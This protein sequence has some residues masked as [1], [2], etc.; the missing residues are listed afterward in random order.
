MYYRNKRN[1]VAFGPNQN[2]FG[3][4]HRAGGAHPGTEQRAVRGRLMLCMVSSMLG[5]LGLGQASDRENTEHQE[6]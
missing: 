1:R 2:N 6:N 4:E 3:V 5:C